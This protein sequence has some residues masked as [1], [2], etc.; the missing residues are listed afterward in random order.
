[1]KTNFSLLFY[2]KKQK[3][4]LEGVAPIYM[5][6]TVKGKRSEITTGRECLPERWNAVAG[7]VNGTKEDVRAFNAYLDDLTKKVYEAHRQLTEANCL[8]T[9]EGLK[10]KFCGKEDRPRLLIEIFK[11]HNLQMSTLVEKGSYSKGTLTCFETALR[12][13]QDFIKW[14]YNVNDFDVTQIN[15]LF[16]T[17]YDYF[18]RTQCNCQNN[19]A[20]KNMKNLGKIIR[21]CE[22]NGWLTANPF[23]N[24]KHKMKRVD[25]VFLSA[26]DDPDI[27]DVISY[28]LLDKGYEVETLTTGKDV[29]NAIQ[30]F[31]PDLIL[32]D[33][34]LGDMDGRVIC[35]NIKS[36][37]ETEKLPII[38]I[39]A[40]HNLSETLNQ[41]G[42]PN[43]FIAKPFDID[44]LVNKVEDQLK[45]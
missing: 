41:D 6:I 14:K 35:S 22:A 18:L 16:I 33:V 17:E 10:N 23:G 38:L 39:S 8:I 40:T 37:T 12:H 34:M 24:Y 32:M 30:H 42:A 13:T 44:R 26:D 7:R 29:S 9:A 31:N 43:D 11:E 5:R 4:Y 28:I 15:H 21:K 1:M 19:T 45:D 25:R 27:L 36:S 3:N 20:V 2:M